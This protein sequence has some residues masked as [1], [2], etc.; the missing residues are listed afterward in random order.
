MTSPTKQVS[1]DDRFNTWHQTLIQHADMSVRPALSHHSILFFFKLLTGVERWGPLFSATH[2]GFSPYG[3]QYIFPQA[4]QIQVL[5]RCWD[6]R[7]FGH[8]DRHGPNPHGP[9]SGRGLLRPFSWCEL[10]PH[11]TQCRLGGGTFVWSGILLIQPTLWPQYTNVTGQTGHRLSNLGRT[12]TCN[13]LPKI[14]RASF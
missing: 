4:M 6:R 5:S 12:V 7:P 9:K 13:G 14:C 1:G 8:S 11:L 3:P 2:A 10:G